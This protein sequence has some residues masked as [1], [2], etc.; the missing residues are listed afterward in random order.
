MHDSCPIRDVHEEIN[1]CIHL[2]PKELSI[3]DKKKIIRSWYN[4]NIKID[5]K[6]LNIK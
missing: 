4:E 3:D 2:I 5:W 1:R 6:K